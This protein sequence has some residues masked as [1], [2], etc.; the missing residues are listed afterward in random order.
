M[1]NNEVYF[2]DVLRTIFSYW[3][4]IAIIAVIS[5]VISYIL[6]LNT[7]TE[8]RATTLLFVPI[9]EQSQS[10]G[11]LGIQ[12]SRQGTIEGMLLSL[13]KSQAL[14]IPVAEKFELNKVYHTS[15][16]SSAHTLSKKIRLYEERGIYVLTVEMPNAQ[17]SADIANHIPIALEA[18]NSRLEIVGKKEILK[19]LDPAIVPGGP[20][21]PNLSRSLQFGFLGGILI[22][23]FLSFVV[24]YIRG[25]FRSPDL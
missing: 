19:V 1:Q 14:L 2:K 3:K 5:L 6:Y 15:I 16:P 11:I 22:G 25:I 24:E 18:L 4:F 10:L 7:P 20:Y 9:E 21:K 12:S 13:L 17:L 8:Y 23:I